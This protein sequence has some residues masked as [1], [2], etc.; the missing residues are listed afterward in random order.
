LQRGQAMGLASGEAIARHFGVPP[1]TAAQLGLAQHGWTG[2]TPLWL[3]I[4]KEAEVLRDGEQLGPVGCRVVGEVLV[5]IIDADPESFRAANP[6]WTPTL[7]AR[8]PGAFGLAD[9]LVPGG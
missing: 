9:I 8:R 1:L 2:E 4:L 6:E 5:G 7:P 3:S